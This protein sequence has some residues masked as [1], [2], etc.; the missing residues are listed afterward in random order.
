MEVQEISGGSRVEHVPRVGDVRGVLRGALDVLG[1]Q[2]VELAQ[3]LYV[4]LRLVQD[5]AD[6]FLGVAQ[7]LEGSGFVADEGIGPGE[8]DQEVIIL[9]EVLP[10]GDGGSVPSSICWMK[11]WSV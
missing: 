5:V 3:A 8:L 2:A 6:A 11:G 4:L 7:V 10:E 1:R 9:D